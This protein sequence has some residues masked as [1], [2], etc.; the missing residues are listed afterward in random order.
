MRVLPAGFAYGYNTLNGARKKQR[1]SHQRSHPNSVAIA[2]KTLAPFDAKAAGWWAAC[3]CPPCALTENASKNV[4]ARHT[5]GHDVSFRKDRTRPGVPR[6][7]G[8][9][10]K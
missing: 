9:V 2:R 4:H 1:Y 7:P 6:S 5:A 8:L 3:V 10:T